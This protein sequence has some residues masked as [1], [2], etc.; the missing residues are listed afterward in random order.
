MI[1]GVALH[2]DSQGAALALGELAELPLRQCQL[3]QHAIGDGQEVLACLREAEAAS[4]PQPDV[5]AELL[6]ELLHAVAQRRLREVEL[7]RGRGERPQALHRVDDRKVGSFKHDQDS[8]VRELIPFYFM[9]PGAQDLRLPVIFESPAMSLVH[10][11][12]FPRI[13]AARELKFALESYW[14]GETPRDALEAQGAALR[15]DQPRPGNCP[16]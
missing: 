4:L 9:N 2:S 7:A 12:G 6:L 14:K 16:F 11:L 8:W 5:R 15:N 1:A 3:R 10:N 13:G